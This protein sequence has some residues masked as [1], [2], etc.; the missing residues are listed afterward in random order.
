M[1]QQFAVRSKKSVFSSQF[2]I[3]A[4]RIAERMIFNARHALRE[5]D[6]CQVTAVGDGEDTI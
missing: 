2:S 1:M 6:A 5:G 4:L 3:S